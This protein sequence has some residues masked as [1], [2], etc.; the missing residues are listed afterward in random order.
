MSA[1]ANAKQLAA[2]SDF[3]YHV[4]LAFQVIDDILDVTG[5]DS[6]LAIDPDRIITAQRR[7]ADGSFEPIS[8]VGLSESSSLIAAI[9]SRDGTRACRTD[10]RTAS[11]HRAAT[12]S[13]PGAS[14]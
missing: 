10:G 6:G 8:V 14:R 12:A 2:L 5:S 3:G 13:R 9:P 7:R 1:N 11:R 4:G